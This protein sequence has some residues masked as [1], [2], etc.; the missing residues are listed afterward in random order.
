MNPPPRHAPTL[1]P[2]QSGTNN[3]LPNYPAHNESP[4][5]PR[6][7]L[8]MLIPLLLLL[9][10]AVDAEMRT[11]T[12]ADEQQQVEAEFVTF[13]A[14]KAWLHRKDGRTFGI[15]LDQL[16][17][18]DQ[19]YIREQIRQREKASAQGTANPPDRIPYGRGR[20]IAHLANP[21]I[22]ESS[23]L[24]ASRSTPDAFWTHNDSGSGPKLFLVDKTGAD[25][26]TF[27]LKHQ[28]AFDWEDIAAIRRHG[29]NYL[30]VG[31]TGNNGLASTIQMLHVVEE[32]LPGDP[33]EVDIVETIHY[34]YEDDHRD[35]EAMAVDPTTET[36]LMITKQRRAGTL[37]YALPW[38]E[39]T[40]NKSF[41]AKKI[42]QLDLPT[43]TAMDISP[44]GRRAVILTYANAYEYQRAA[45][46]SWR[47]AFARPPREIVAPERIQG[48]SICYG[49]DGQTLYLTS[50]KRP[51][52]LIEIPVQPTE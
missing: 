43:A 3:G 13:Q 38:P 40:P 7:S 31:D 41:P 33:Q 28:E 2:H 24:V 15:P 50:E 32:P 44:D 8:T 48:E 4:R 26:G 23:G 6:P 16:S 12:S 35:C 51:T 29:K 27:R 45:D 9:S 22:A 18:S 36:I 10:T 11:W 52:P 1:A 20:T 21:D 5:M 30:M 47:E 19:A 42:G 14:E 39:A 34:S 37:V 25:L 17:K 49:P 46:E